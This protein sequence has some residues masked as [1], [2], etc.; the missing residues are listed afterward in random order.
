MPRLKSRVRIPSPAPVFQG[1]TSSLFPKTG[2]Q[3]IFGFGWGSRILAKTGVNDSASAAKSAKRPAVAAKGAVTESKTF[4]DGL[5]YLYKRADFKKPTW[6]CRVKVPGGVEHVCWS[7][8]E[9]DAITP[10]LES[11]ICRVGVTDS[12][13]QGGDLCCEF[14]DFN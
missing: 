10:I 12:H 7:T 8:Y 4:R 1:V 9:A 14:G 6:L 5:I 2:F 13:S 3:T 11:W